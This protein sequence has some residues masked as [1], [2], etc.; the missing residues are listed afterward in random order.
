[1]AKFTF[2]SSGTR[3]IYFGQ[4]NLNRSLVALRILYPRQQ[5]IHISSRFSIMQLEN[6]RTITHEIM[7]KMDCKF[8]TSQGFCL[9]IIVEKLETSL[10]TNEENTVDGQVI[11]GAEGRY[12][13]GVSI[14][15]EYPY[16]NFLHL[17]DQIKVLDG[18]LFLH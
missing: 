13:I 15:V 7:F 9:L 17:S 18:Y 2:S 14:F 6:Q 12:S 1:M 3:T 10:A 8:T 4:R 11:P 5:V 16:N